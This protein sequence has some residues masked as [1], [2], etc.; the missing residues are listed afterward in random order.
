MTVIPPEGISLEDLQATNEL[1]LKSGGTIREMNTVRRHLCQLKGGKLVQYAQPAYVY[2]ITL[3][4][5]DDDIMPWPD[6]SKPDPTT[7]QDAI[8]IVEFYNLA[9]RI[10]Q[11]V[12]SY[13]YE[14]T[15]HE[16]WET[17]KS[18]TGMRHMLLSV[19]NP[20]TA[21]EAAA[22]KA[23]HLGYPSHILATHLEGD[24]AEIGIF[25]AGITNEILKNNRPFCKPCALISGGETTVTINGEAGRGGPNMEMVLSFI[26]YMNAS[27]GWAA[28]SIDTD[29][30]D[31]PTQYAGA[32]A[33]PLTKEEIY[34]TGF[35]MKERLKNHA[36][37]E[38]FLRT[39]NIIHT[40]HTGTNVMNL[41]VVLIGEV[42]NEGG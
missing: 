33:D 23:E 16:E 14:G 29:G 27:Q 40:G 6:M 5:V 8:D 9:D 17:V 39:N 12:I 19:G 25:L 7:Y 37:E 31:G 32:I 21:C 26:N 10:P 13:L 35:R 15:K 34:N 2:T 28:A 24:S 22:Q 11:S 1:L 42:E 4:T 18:L 36:S 30:T 38:V 41:R 3:D 20:K